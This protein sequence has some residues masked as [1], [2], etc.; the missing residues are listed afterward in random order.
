MGGSSGGVEEGMGMEMVVEGAD[1]LVPFERA[2][3]LCRGISGGK[4]GGD[5]VRGGVGWE[6]KE[7]ADVDDLSEEWV[8]YSDVRARF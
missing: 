2:Q 1:Y 5:E 8:K 4:R 7:G 6:D 3:G